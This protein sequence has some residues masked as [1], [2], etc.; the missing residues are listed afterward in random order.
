MSGLVSSSYRRYSDARSQKNSQVSVNSYGYRVRLARDWQVFIQEN[1][2]SAAEVQE[3]FGVSL[4][5]AEKWF[6][7]N[8]T[9]SPS[10]FA[11][12]LAFSLL[13]KSAQKFLGVNQ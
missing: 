12:G 2:E 13:P 1:F 6:Y 7:G 9:H 4:S 10:G 5:T 11:V 3:F 8:G